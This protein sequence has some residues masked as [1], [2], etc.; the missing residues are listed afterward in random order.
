MTKQAIIVI[1]ALVAGCGV[2]EPKGLE[3]S[4]IPWDEL[5]PSIDTVEPDVVDGDDVAALDGG[6]DVLVWP[7]EGVEPVTNSCAAGAPRRV[8]GVVFYDGPD[9]PAGAALYLLMDENEIPPPGIPDCFIGVQD[10]VFPAY[11]EFQEVWDGEPRY[12]MA[13]IKVDGNFPPVPGPAD[14]FARVPTAGP[15]PMDADVFWLKLYP[16]PYEED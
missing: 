1:C 13:L 12:V 14:W 8:G 11:F 4:V 9:L 16:A 5:F 3:D 15:L 7:P 2:P 6:P 10:P